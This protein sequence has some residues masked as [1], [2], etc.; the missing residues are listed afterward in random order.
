ML[1]KTDFYIDGAW[2]PPTTSKDF[3]VINP[4]DE[5][6]FGVISLGSKADVDKAVAAARAA[7][8]GWSKTPLADRIAK[9]EKLAEV[10]ERRAG[11]MAEAISTE[12]GAPMKLAT[13]AQAAAGLGHIKAFIRALKDFKFEH[14]LRDDTPDEFIIHEAIG[15]CGLITPWNW[16]M[17]QVTLKVVPA[18]GVGCTVVLKPSEIAPMSSLLFAE[19]MDEA[20][21]P[22]GVFN[23]VN[24]DG[25]TVG[26]AMSRH[27]DID[28]MSFTGS[29]RAGIAVTQASAETV[30]RVALELGGKGANIVFADA[31][32]AKAV[33]RGA[34][35]CFNNT[36]QSCNAPTRM[37]VERSVYDEAVEVACATA[38]STAVGLPSE[39]GN[40]IGPL[41]SE[42]QFTK[43]QDLIQAGI[44]EGA[45]LVAGGTGRPEGFNRGY[46]VRPTVFA[47]V[48]ND[49]RIAREE[50]FG[51]VLSMIP[52]ESEDEAVKISNDTSYGL[53]DYVQ[54]GDSARTQRVARQLRAGMVVANG[55]PRAPGSPFGGY[56]QSGNGREGGQYGLTEFLEVKAVSGWTTTS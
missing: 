36:G 32:V 7:F 42:L 19:F 48:N 29:T 55:A 44:D 26:E 40:H 16:P 47:D 22:K 9:V 39:D 13:T 4:A 18:V 51:P 37:L 25:P 49:M 30:K 28:M 15:V 17:N 35:H 33:K 45:R 11:E 43:V 52:F 12:M 54:S 34:I 2:V 20:G 41:V 1:R 24:G 27:P 31:D 5:T 21:F 8:D 46:F 3:D 23:L 56:K 50:I 6:A 53:T 10:Y 38:E 14:K